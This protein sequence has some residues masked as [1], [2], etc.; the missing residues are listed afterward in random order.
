MF[1]GHFLFKGRE[2]GS[3]LNLKSCDILQL[4]LLTEADF[5]FSRPYSLIPPWGKEQATLVEK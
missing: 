4:N 3:S 2:G 1:G 5:I